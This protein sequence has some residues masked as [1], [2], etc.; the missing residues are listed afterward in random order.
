MKL[1]IIFT[2][3]P[4]VVL[5]LARGLSLVVSRTVSVR[6]ERPRSLHTF[7]VVLGK[8]LTPAILPVIRVPWS[9]RP[10]ERS[11]V[12]RGSCFLMMDLRSRFFTFRV[13]CGEVCGVLSVQ[14][15]DREA[16]AVIRVTHAMGWSMWRR[17]ISRGASAGRCSASFEVSW[18]VCV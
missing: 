15:V 2:A 12:C 17:L 13:V 7:A 14:R 11:E 16:G 10:Q 6:V 18:F 9:F 5:Y 3:R 4:L 8:V 1:Q